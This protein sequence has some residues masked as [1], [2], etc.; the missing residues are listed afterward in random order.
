MSHFSFFRRALVLAA[1]AS[2]CAAQAQNFPSKTLSLIVP[3]P[4]GGPADATA[5]WLEPGLRKSLG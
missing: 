5:R 2:A 1:L 4:A 3:Y